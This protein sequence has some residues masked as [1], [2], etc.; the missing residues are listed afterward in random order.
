[1]TDAERRERYA[2]SIAL[3]ETSTNL[4]NVATV[5]GFLG[6]MFFWLLPIAVVLL[7]AGMFVSRHA[8]K[9]SPYGGKA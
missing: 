4:F 2:R 7:I 9:V 3:Y 1:M 6:V 8:D 5:F